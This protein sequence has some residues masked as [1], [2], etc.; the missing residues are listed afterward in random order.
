LATAALLL[1]HLSI[2]IAR[3]EETAVPKQ[4]TYP[5]LEDQ[6]TNK[7]QIT[8]DELEK[9]KKELINARDKAKGSTAPTKSKKP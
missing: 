1:S 2:S 4:G 7:P 3:A 8:A 6:P 9:L 5:R